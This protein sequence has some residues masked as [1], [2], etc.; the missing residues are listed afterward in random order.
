MIALHRRDDPL[1][2]RDDAGGAMLAFG[3]GRS[4][5]DSC[6]ID[7][8][9]MLLT[10]GLDRFIALDA[11]AGILRCEA[12]V[13][14]DTI[15]NLL[16]PQGWFLPVVPG[17]AQV[18]VGGAIAND[19][20][21]KNHH[22]VGSFGRHVTRFEL[23]RSDGS[24]RIC[25]RDENAA[26]F[27]AT[28]GGLGLTGLIT[29]VEIQLARIASPW[30][31]VETL[32]FQGLDEFLAVSRESDWTHEYTVAW[33]DG[34]ARPEQRWRGVFSRANFVA[35]DAGPAEPRSRLKVPFA[36][37][38]RVLRNWT[39][40]LYNGLHLRRNPPGF[41]TCHYRPFF[42]PLDGVSHWN[43]LYGPHGFVQ[44]QCVLPAAAVTE[45]LPRLLEATITAGHP[46]YLAVLK[47]FGDLP[48]PG[49]LSFPREGTTLAMDFPFCGEPTR[50]LL[51]HLNALVADAD[52]AV[53]PAKDAHMHARHFRRFFPD[54]SR[55]TDHVDPAF[56]SAFWQRVRSGS[57]TMEDL[58]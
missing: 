58:F 56:S 9:K 21:G 53:Y 23:V 24:R 48:S 51:D 1:P 47:S 3:N 29:W 10:R 41:S 13:L 16:A 25:A 44:H 18:T 28:I 7:D 42:F 26:L 2:A 46:P 11:Q 57:D 38:F 54:W 37:P 35:T 6:L 31:R 50:R 4:Y 45:V 27:A 20:H 22:R 19:I 52:G 49:L 5:G 32:S 33:I 36:P 8:G 40:R 55:F 15:L 12:G 14:L 17:T 34:L 30:L 43:R 39:Q